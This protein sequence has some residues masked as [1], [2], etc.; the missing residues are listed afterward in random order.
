MAKRAS[1][2]ELS[3]RELEQLRSQRL[4]EIAVLQKDHQKLQQ[5]MNNLSERLSELRGQRRP[6]RP[7]ARA[8][9]ATAAPATA[10]RRRGR[11]RRA[12]NPMP[13]RAVLVS[14]LEKAG[15]PLKTAELMD[16]VTKSGYKS[17]SKNLRAVVYQAIYN[18]PEIVAAKDGSGYVLKGQ[19]GK[20]GGRRQ[21]DGP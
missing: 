9:P 18:A 1:G 2:G 6:G 5:Q 10:R 11:R 17:I 16:E 21:A 13:L 15:K 19:R 4:K 7:S 8:A 12:K 3:L 14:S 20:A